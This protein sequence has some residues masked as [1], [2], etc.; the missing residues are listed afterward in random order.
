MAKLTTE[1]R[2]RLPHHLFACPRTDPPSY[3][4][5]SRS[6]IANAR[7]RTKQHGQKCSGQKAKICGAARR[8]GMMKPSYS[9]AEGWS[10]WCLR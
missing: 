10:K 1:Q 3:P 8:K 4:L 7:T 5:D 6:R 2:R 9:G